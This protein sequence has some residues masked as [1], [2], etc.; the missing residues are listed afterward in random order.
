[1]DKEYFE[2]IKEKVINERY[3]LCMWSKAKQRYDNQ[4]RLLNNC[5]VVA[6][7]ARKIMITTF[8]NLVHK[9]ANGFLRSYIQSVKPEQITRA[10][11][12]LQEFRH[13]LQRLRPRLISS[14]L[15]ESVIVNAL[16]D[17]EAL[18]AYIFTKYNFK[19]IVG[20]T[21]ESDR[22]RLDHED[23]WKKVYEGI[24][25]QFPNLDMQ[26]VNSFGSLLL[27]A[28]EKIL[29]EDQY[30]FCHLCRKMITAEFDYAFSCGCMHLVCIECAFRAV[31]K[32]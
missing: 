20:R 1:M 24:N 7:S 16:V 12:I 13:M 26:V 15:K 2:N 22:F 27:D 6:T 11:C 9:M 14:E 8:A 32:K 17:I 4:E 29:L 10:Y 31:A 18:T 30:D 3:F 5:V 21:G 23:F 25:C 28:T 19:P